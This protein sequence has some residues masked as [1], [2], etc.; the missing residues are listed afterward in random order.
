[1][2]FRE[3]HLRRSKTARAVTIIC[4]FTCIFSSIVDLDPALAFSQGF[5]DG[6]F[7]AIRPIALA[8]GPI[9]GHGQVWEPSSKGSILA[10]LGKNHPVQVPRDEWDDGIW[11]DAASYARDESNGV[12]DAWPCDPFVASLYNEQE[13]VDYVALKSVAKAKRYMSEYASYIVA[14]LQ[15]VNRQLRAKLKV[16]VEILKLGK[17]PRVIHEFD[18]G[19]TVMAHSW[20]LPLEAFIKSRLSWKG[21]A[22]RDKWKPV[23]AAVDR[24]GGDCYVVCLDDV[25]RDGNT[26]GPDFSALQV[27][28]TR[29]GLDLHR[30]GHLARLLRRGV[31][32]TTAIGTVLSPVQRLLSGASFTSGMNWVTSRFVWWR[33]CRWMGLHSSEYVVICEGDDN[34][35]VICGRAYRRRR[36]HRVLTEEWIRSAGLRCGKRLKVEAM[37]WQRDGVAWPCVGGKAVFADGRWKFMPSWDRALIKAGWAINYDWQSYRH[38][39]GRITARAWALNDRFDGVPVFWQYA[40]AVAAY[41]EVFGQCPIFDDDESRKKD[42]EGWAG[43]LAA[44][45]DDHSRLCYAIAYGVGVGDQLLLE[46]VIGDAVKDGDWTRDLTREFHDIASRE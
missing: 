23:A 41:A 24:F 36:L 34:V 1:V 7:D 18:G 9:I 30:E 35:G 29:L 19:E 21:L 20:A 8:C 39:G 4:M 11:R 33:I 6:A 27:L 5:G 26:I 44:S 13:V 12:Y 2:E 46:S 14:G 45:P 16:K 43:G 22:T 31:Y 32:L 28:L 37:G 3:V 42:E 15:R 38:A 25:A 40:R 10:G 17:P